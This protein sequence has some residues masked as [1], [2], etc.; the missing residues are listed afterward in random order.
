MHLA[1]SSRRDESTPELGCEI[2]L[3]G[4]GDPN[5][6]TVPDSRPNQRDNSPARR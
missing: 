6:L 1:V 5:R 4:S 3:A 2:P